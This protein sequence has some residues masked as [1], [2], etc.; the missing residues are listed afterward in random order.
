MDATEE[1]GVHHIIFYFEASLGFGYKG[2][3]GKSSSKVFISPSSNNTSGVIIV[4]PIY[5]FPYFLVVPLDI[6]R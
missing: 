2:G 5:I 1:G 4:A 6:R 3:F